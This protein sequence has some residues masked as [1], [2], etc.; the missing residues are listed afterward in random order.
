MA[1]AHMVSA[2]PIGTRTGTFCGVRPNPTTT[3][4]SASPVVD[5][6]ASGGG[7]GR[8]AGRGAA[9][10]GVDAPRP[11]APLSE[12]AQRLA[13]GAIRSILEGILVISQRLVGLAR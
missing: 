4:I 5:T 6:G 9:G 13:K 1:P 3:M 8:G 7:G 2:R 10:D 12:R 11:G